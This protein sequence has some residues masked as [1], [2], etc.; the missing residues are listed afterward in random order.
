[1]AVKRFR[2][3]V[4]V[5]SIQLTPFMKRIVLTG[6]DLMDF[7]D[8]CESGYIKLLFNHDGEPINTVQQVDQLAPLKPLMRTYTIRAYDATTKQLTVDFALHPA[9]SGPA[10]N[11]ANATKAGDTIVIAGPGPAK[12]AKTDKDWVFFVGDMTSLPA[13]SCNLEQLPSSTKGL[14]VI[15]ITSEKDK[16]VLLKPANVDIHWVLKDHSPTSSALTEAVKQVDWLEGEPYVWSASEFS[17]MRNLRKHFKADL[18]VPK[19]AIYISSYW[20]FGESEDQHKI[21]KQKDAAS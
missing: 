16:Q 11:W 21:T 7:P 2:Q 5:S 15:E 1:M 20:K 9:T 10:S 4:V 14:A 6:A 3:V 19:S 18:G 8:N 12:F 13:I 17:T